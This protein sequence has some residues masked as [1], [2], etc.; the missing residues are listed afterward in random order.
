MFL[1]GI[2]TLAR[3]SETC[4]RVIRVTRIKLAGCRWPDH[5]V[6]NPLT[7]C[8]DITLTTKAEF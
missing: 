7:F 4:F 2:A 1:M 3:R 5:H 8:P 6:S